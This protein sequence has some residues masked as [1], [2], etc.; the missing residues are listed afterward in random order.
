M[1]S[2]SLIV[3]TGAG[4]SADSGIPTFRGKEGMWTKGSKNYF[5]EELATYSSFIQSP[6]ILWDWYMYRQKICAEAE[7]NEGHLGIARLEQFCKDKG[8]EFL[9]ITQNVDN[10]HRRA[11]SENIIEIHGNIFKMRCSS[12]SPHA[13]EIKEIEEDKKCKICGE[14]MRPHVLWFDEYYDDTLFQTKSALQ[15][16]FQADLLIVVGTT[17]QTTIPYEIVGIFVR[18]GKSIVEINPEPVLGEFTE[19]VL[20]ESSSTALP[21]II[22]RLK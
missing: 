13:Y 7:L 18:S 4:V 19:L 20:S 1:K 10:L 16:A 9:L 22:A 14:T 11:G 17:L 8:K 21:E 15:R 12:S 2:K 3:L 5:P 6:E